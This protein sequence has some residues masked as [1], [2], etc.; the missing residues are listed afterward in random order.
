MKKYII[1]LLLLIGIGAGLSYMTISQNKLFD[2]DVFLK[3]TASIR[4][5]KIIDNT[6]NILLFKMHYEDADNYV[7]LE[8]L[9]LNISEEFDNLRFEA[10]LEEIE[11]SETLERETRG[12]ES[13]LTEKLDNIERFVEF[14]QRLL[15]ARDTFAD[16]SD[17]NIPFVNAIDALSL[18]SVI[19]EIFIDF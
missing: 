14:H 19:D 11:S 7:A 18:N 10:L 13:S 8:E 4:N 9:G 3:T 16:Y 17:N 5:L 2:Q 15:S 1:G 6:V 12:F